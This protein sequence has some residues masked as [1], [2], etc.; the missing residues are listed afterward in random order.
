LVC[1]GLFPI[2]N[3]FTARAVILWRCS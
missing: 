2:Q 1:S 3:L